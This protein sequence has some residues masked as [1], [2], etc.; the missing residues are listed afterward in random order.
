[1]KKMIVEKGT[2]EKYPSKKAMM[3]HEKSEGKTMQKK[4]AV[5]MKKAMPAK[6]TVVMMKKK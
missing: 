6:K 2:M 3:K 5:M 4:E 1:M